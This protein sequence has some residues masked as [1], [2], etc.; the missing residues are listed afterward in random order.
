MEGTRAAGPTTGLEGTDLAG[1]SSGGEG[2]NVAC[3]GAYSVE[4]GVGLRSSRVGEETCSP[5]E[6]I[7]NTGGED[8]TAEI[9]A[10]ESTPRTSRHS[11]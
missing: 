10:V 5:L 1:P 9:A 3:V 8:S 7:P 11:I 4:V 6:D 2:T